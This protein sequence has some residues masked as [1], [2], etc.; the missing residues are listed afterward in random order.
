MKNYCNKKT[1]EL[2][3]L[4]TG[5]T[6]QTRSGVFFLHVQ[7]KKKK[8]QVLCNKSV[9]LNELGQFAVSVSLEFSEGLVSKHF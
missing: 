7:K 9:Y 8:K 3:A 6:S 5:S 4:H 1:S 2:S